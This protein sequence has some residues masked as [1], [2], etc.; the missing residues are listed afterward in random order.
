MLAAVCILLMCAVSAAGTRLATR[1]PWQ[2]R[3]ERAPPTSP[4]RRSNYVQVTIDRPPWFIRI[5]A[6]AALFYAQ[7][8]L[9]VLAVALTQLR[10][11]GIAVGL[12][13]LGALAVASAVAGVDQLRPD[14]GTSGRV[15]VL[16]R[17]LMAYG[18]PL[19][20]FGVLH[21]MV[22]EQEAST[23]VLS[24]GSVGAGL[25]ATGVIVAALLLLSTSR[26]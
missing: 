13:P 4:Y 12:L 25:G 17:G 19:V 11:D 8:T 2:V 3:Q 23:G 21:E 24:F 1:S 9:A 16:A 20:G 14:S 7:F 22:L 6:G 15:R 5:A 26:V 10:W 18:I